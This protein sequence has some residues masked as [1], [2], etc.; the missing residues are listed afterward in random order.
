MTEEDPQF[1][2]A[3]HLAEKSALKLIARAEQ[4]SLR[5]AAKLENKGF[6][7]AVVKEVVSRLLD[8]DLLNDTRYAEL[9]IRSRLSS[10]KKISPLWLRSSLSRKGIGME[11]SQKALEK[12]L[13]PETEYSLLLRYLGVCEDAPEV[14]PRNEVSGNKEGGIKRAF[15][16]KEG[17][18]VAVLDRYYNLL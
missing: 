1:D 11:S 15:L 6:D 4:N 7:A 17:F 8:R 5:L 2:A 13:D 10:E 9:W 18:S 14:P 12:I 3:C 16:K